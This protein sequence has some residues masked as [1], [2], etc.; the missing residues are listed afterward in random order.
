MSL[1]VYRAEDV[2]YYRKKSDVL[3]V[4]IRDREDFLK[5]HILG[6]V[7]VPLQKLNTFLLYKSKSM[8]IILCCERGIASS[9][10]AKR[11]SECGYRMGTV[12]GGVNAYKKLKGNSH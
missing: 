8:Q 11:Y 2:D 5:Y 6:V 9:R 1:R 10:E 12:A 3:L 4:D 7:H